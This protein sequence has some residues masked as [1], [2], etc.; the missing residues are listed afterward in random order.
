MTYLNSG[1]CLT[2]IIAHK[3]A[4]N[5]YFCSHLQKETETSQKKN[6]TMLHF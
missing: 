5:I 6:C 2:N 3:S 1:A 4:Y